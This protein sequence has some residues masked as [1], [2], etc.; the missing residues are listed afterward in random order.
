MKEVIMIEIDETDDGATAKIDWS[1]SPR[2]K[3]AKVS[4]MNKL[5]DEINKSLKDR[6]RGN[7]S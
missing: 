7:D 4:T 2:K 3:I 6:W 5:F 1:F